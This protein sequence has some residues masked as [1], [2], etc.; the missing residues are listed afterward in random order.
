MGATLETDFSKSSFYTNK[1]LTTLLLEYSEEFGIIFLL[2][3]CP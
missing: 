3:I 1:R 2:M